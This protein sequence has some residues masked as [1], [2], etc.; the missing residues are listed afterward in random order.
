MCVQK[1]LL[2]VRSFVMLSCHWKQSECFGSR[3]RSTY[4]KARIDYWNS[5]CRHWN[6]QS[7]ESST[8]TNFCG[9]NGQFARSRYLDGRWWNAGASSTISLLESSTVDRYRSTT[10]VKCWR[11]ISVLVTRSIGNRPGTVVVRIYFNINLQN[12]QLSPSSLVDPIAFH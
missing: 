4:G 12:T 6:W 8:E 10:I 3:W 9:R 2:T 7:T 1:S 5:R 11:F